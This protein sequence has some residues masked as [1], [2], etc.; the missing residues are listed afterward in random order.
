MNKHIYA[1]EIKLDAEYTYDNNNNKVYNVT[2]LR[3][4]FNNFVK[5]LKKK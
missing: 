5:T 3:R 4:Q 2:K 1:K